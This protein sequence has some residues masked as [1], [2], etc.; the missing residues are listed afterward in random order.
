MDLYCQVCGEPFEAYHM[1]HDVT[2]EER[3]YFYNG[4]GC[5][6][7]NGTVPLSGRPEIAQLATIAHELMGDDIDGIA[8]MLEDYS[9][10][11]RFDGGSW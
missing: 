2:V 6:S 9:Y 7:C 10:M 3:E 8:S 5:A 11:D 1:Q 4:F